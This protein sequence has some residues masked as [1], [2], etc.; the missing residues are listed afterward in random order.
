[1]SSPNR[2]LITGD[3]R[4]IG[5]TFAKHYKSHGLSVIATVRDPANTNEH[6]DMQLEKI[7]RLD[8]AN[9]ESNLEA[10]ATVGSNTPIDLPSNNAV[11]AHGPWLVTRAFL[12]NLEFAANIERNTSGAL[13]AYRSSKTA[14]N[15]LT[16]SLSVDLKPRG[17]MCI[18]LHPGYVQT[19]MT[20]HNGEITTEE[21]VAGLRTILF[22]CRRFYHTDG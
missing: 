18:L 2:V 14:L 13:N 1:M 5:L 10:A 9:E 8:A 4:A 6:M 15:C 17:I 16:K 3:S 22:N 11:N 21:S 19:D 12:P 7:L 20:A